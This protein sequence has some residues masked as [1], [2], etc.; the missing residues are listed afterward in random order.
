MAYSVTIGERVTSVLGEL[1]EVS[2]DLLL[3]E[4]LAL[5]QDPLGKGRELDRDGN[6]HRRMLGVGMLGI[7]AYCVDPDAK[8]VT[9]VDLIAV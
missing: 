4:M 5:A 9:V 8:L 3:L 7:I 6:L 2:H 1:D